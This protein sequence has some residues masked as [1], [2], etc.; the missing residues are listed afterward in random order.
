MPQG[1]VSFAEVKRAVTMEAVLTRYGLKEIL[2]PKGKNLVGLCP[3]CKGKSARQFQ[4]NPVKNAWYCFG[5]KAGG[6]ILDFVAKKERVGIRAA[7]L[8]L[9]GWFALGL[10]GEAPTEKPPA[11]PNAPAPSPAPPVAAESLPTTNPPLTFTLKTLDRHHASLSALGLGAETIEHFG[12]GYCTKGLLKGRLAIPIHNGEGELVAYAGL[13]VEEDAS[14][15]YLFPPKF[16]P[17]LEVFNLERLSAPRE[18]EGP[19]YLSPEIGGVLKLVDAGAHAALGLFDG[20]L[21]AEQ[22]EAIAGA[23]TLYD[24]LVLIGDGF[25]DRTVARLSRRASVSWVPE[26]SLDPLAHSLEELLS[27]RQEEA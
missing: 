2:V 12:A 13:A 11:A 14:P 24:R 21:S 9:D 23:L 25:P 19:L 16:N 17:A 4:V 5:C 15:R 10:A 18:S 26:L 1:F 8:K 6:N 27:L 20:T 22:E 7:A 3:F